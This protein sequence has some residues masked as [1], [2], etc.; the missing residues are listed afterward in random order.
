MIKG[1]QLESEHE[2]SVAFFYQTQISS[3]LF[4]LVKPKYIEN[5]LA[6]L[7]RHRR[8]LAR[9]L[10]LRALAA[11]LSAVSAVSLAFFG[12]PD[13]FRFGQVY[14][15]GSLNKKRVNLNH[16]FGAW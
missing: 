10:S 4:L 14:I 16:N 7:L 5:G 11:H 12:F 13:R 9:H 15:V 3:C 8:G 1:N 6:S 2:I